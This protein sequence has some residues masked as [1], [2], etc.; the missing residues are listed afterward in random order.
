[1]L[2]EQ[3]TQANIRWA[4]NT[5]TTN[6]VTRVNRVIVVSTVS[7][8]SGTAAGVTARSANSIE[9]VEELVRQSETAARANGAAE[10]AAPLLTPAEIP[11]AE[12]PDW[13]QPPSES[14]FT[15]FSN[16]TPGLGASLESA[17]A[18]ARVLAGFASHEQSSLFL[19][20]S[21][22]LRL[23][24]DQPTGKVEL[25]GRSNDGER[26]AWIGAS[27]RDFTDVDATALDAHIQ[28]RLDWAKRK[29]E[30]PAGRYETVLPPTAVA[31]LL[32]YL[33]W[34]AGG[35]DAH[36]GRTVFSR[37]GGGTRIGDVLTPVPITLRSDP[38]ATG[39]SC[40]PFVAAA[41]STSD[42]SVFDNG[43][44]TQ[45]T[46]WIDEG[47]LAALITTRHSAEVTGLP[48]APSVDNLILDGTP[49]GADV[50]AMIAGT[51]RGLLLT[52]LWYIREVDPQTLLLT[53]LTR[54]GVFLIEDGDVV[55]AVNNFRFNESPLDVL[56]R[57]IEL[58]A[59][60]PALPREW[61]DYFTRTAMP[62]LRV[63][64]FNMSSVSQA[65]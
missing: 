43:L 29:I 45:A 55:G 51:E 1:V 31:D 32:V 39:L 63:A 53:G 60:E 41:T 15:V 30:L 40:A 33:Y 62:P 48:I 35:R 64:D 3:A 11:V 23:R 49:G 22:G 50:A 13:A 46:R 5:L 21:T 52:C 6:G 58:G 12:S 4:A 28:Q 17:R 18:D 10:D 37:A 59:T 8:K 19:G 20:T 47:R 38:S 27:T 7:G 34:T 9:A 44:P 16:F 56:G 26:S 25:T 24:H 36:D 14:S 65:M 42:Q 57:I 54:D 2:V 61:S